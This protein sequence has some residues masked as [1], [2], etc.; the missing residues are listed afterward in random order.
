[1]VGHAYGAQRLAFDFARLCSYGR[2]DDR[3]RPPR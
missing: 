2:F 3:G 1:M